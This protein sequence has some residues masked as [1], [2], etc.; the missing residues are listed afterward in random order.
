MAANATG[1]V[2]GQF[3]QHGQ[4]GKPSMGD[5]RGKRGKKAT[6]KDASVLRDEDADGDSPTRGAPRAEGDTAPDS[7]SVF[8]VYGAPSSADQ[9]KGRVFE[10]L[11]PKTQPEYLD[12]THE[13]GLDSVS[14][15]VEDVEL[16]DDDDGTMDLLAAYSEA[17]ERRGVSKRTQLPG[18]VVAKRA[19]QNRAAMLVPQSDP[20]GLAQR[21]RELEARGIP[22]Q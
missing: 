7:G 12:E 22:C 18:R 8:G 13:G 2:P 16:N 9:Y 19:T 14:T 17:E 21:R 5:Q 11:V 10:D 20:L 3:D 1:D 6:F 4:Y 15:R